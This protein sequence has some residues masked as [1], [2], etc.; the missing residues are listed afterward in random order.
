M[1]WLVTLILLAVTA[2]AASAQ[3]QDEPT[4]T[5]GSV[6]D[7]TRGI[8]IRLTPPGS[9]IDSVRVAYA[10]VWSFGHEENRLRPC[11]RWTPDSLGGAPFAPDR[12]GLGGSTDSPTYAGKAAPDS[13]FYAALS[14]ERPVGSLPALFVRGTGRVVGPGAYGHFGMTRYLVR[15]E[16]YGEVRWAMPED[17]SGAGG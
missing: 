2:S 9:Y 10:G 3:T 16:D 11:G 17:C 6:P 14:G 5:L 12:I 13:S 8:V 4:P 1:H 7:S 15:T